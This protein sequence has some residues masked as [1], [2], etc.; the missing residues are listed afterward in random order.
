MVSLDKK[1][2]SERRFKFAKT[3]L[4]LLLCVSLVCFIHAID[5]RADNISRD[6]ASSASNNGTASNSRFDHHEYAYVSSWPIVDRKLGSVSAV[7]FDCTGNVVIFHRASHVWSLGSFD[8]ENRFQNATEGPI[9]QHTVLTFSSVTGQIIREWGENLFY[10]PHGL[11]IDHE[12]NYWLTDVALHQ[13]F[14]FD[15]KHSLSEPVL[16]LGQ[17]FEPGHDME[18]FCKPT[19]VA[20][21]KNGDFFVADGYCNGRI[22]KY[23]PDGQPLLM[24]GRN[25]FILT[26]TFELPQG[27]VPE[28]FF[29]IPHAL[30]L[31]PDRGLLCVADREQGRVQCFHTANGTYHSQY[32]SPDIGG[33][34]F[35]VKYVATNGGLLYIIN[36]PQFT[37]DVKPVQ[38]FILEMQTGRVVGS[39][40][41][42]NLLHAFANP[43]ELAVTRDGAEVY[44]AELNPQMVHKFRRIVKVSNALLLQ[45]TFSTEALPMF[46]TGNRVLTASSIGIFSIVSTLLVTSLLVILMAR[47]I[48]FRPGNSIPRMDEL[49]LRNMGEA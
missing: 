41:P 14:K 48:C 22:I 45:E 15:L 39:F 6:A 42:N 27:P 47:V 3:F 4:K 46:G 20:V 36:G 8:T 9:A 38:G 29:A 16:V 49:P 34:L 12:D 25:S 40:Q 10:M 33:R 23:S 28:S 30:T 17:R 18:H 37:I 44:V 11:A 2:I 5:A 7:D 1:M 19:S 26:R 32:S 21:L 43:H 31:V 24:W 13:V 35:S